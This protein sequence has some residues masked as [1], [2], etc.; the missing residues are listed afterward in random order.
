MVALERGPVA[1][2]RLPFCSLRQPP[3]PNC[4]QCNLESGNPVS[5]SW[6]SPLLRQLAPTPN[7]PPPTATAGWGPKSVC[8]STRAGG[9]GESTFLVAGAFTR[10]NPVMKSILP[11]SSHHPG[12][13]NSS[14]IC[15]L[16][17]RFKQYSFSE[18][19]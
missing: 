5:H 18:S 16:S 6:K 7:S 10:T 11:C 9:P 8:A 3:K 15:S 2:V 19:R 1:A 13:I 14:C 12:G 17:A 4:L